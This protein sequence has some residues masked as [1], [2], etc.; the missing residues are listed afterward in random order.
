MKYDNPEL[1]EQLAAEYVLGTMPILVRRRFERLMT[2]DLALREL[3]ENW[4]T[5]FG[6]IDHAELEEEP[7]AHVWRA[8]ERRLAL[9]PMSSPEPER[10]GWLSSLAFWRGATLAAAAV[11]AVAVFFV[12]Q[13]PSPPTTVA[14]ILSNDK[15]DPGWVALG[16]PGGGD[17]AVA[18]IQKVAIDASHAFELWAI[19]EGPPHPLGLLTPEPGHPL[20]VQAS[21]VPANGV[22]AISLEPAGGSPTGLPTGPVEYKGKVLPRAP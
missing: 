1:R 15:G 4:T 10:S 6:P 21:L 9:P 12:V 8:V 18:P 13:A 14:A 17:I 19:A 5:R 7:P 16:A 20:I 22:L 2:S 3:V 11:A